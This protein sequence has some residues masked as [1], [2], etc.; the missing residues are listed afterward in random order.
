MM[1]QESEVK[2]E[3]LH[4]FRILTTLSSSA[5][6]TTLIALCRILQ[7]SRQ[8]WCIKVALTQ[9]KNHRMALDFFSSMW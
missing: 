8:K 1:P 6:R 9:V 2:H 5:F 4:R 3:T 7:Q